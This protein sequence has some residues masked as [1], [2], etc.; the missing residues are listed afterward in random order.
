MTK[1]KTEPAVS[2][3]EVTFATKET[4]VTNWRKEKVRKCFLFDRDWNCHHDTKTYESEAAA[5]EIRQTCI[6]DETK[7]YKMIKDNTPFRVK[8]IKKG[9][10]NEKRKV[11]KEERR[12]V[13]RIRCTKR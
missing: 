8:Y 13:S 9:R 3:L 5:E 10:N 4:K 2:S 11:K 12:S 6:E 1:V 7:S